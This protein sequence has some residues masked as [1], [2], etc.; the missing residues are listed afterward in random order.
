MKGVAE[1][2]KKG[3]LS[4]L[5]ELHNQFQWKLCALPAVGV[6]WSRND[7]MTHFCTGCV[8]VFEVPEVQVSARC[9]LS[10][11]VGPTLNSDAEESRGSG[12]DQHSFRP[13]SSASGLIVPI[14]FL[15]SLESSS[16]SQRKGELE[17]PSPKAPLSFNSK[18]EWWVKALGSWRLAGRRSLYEDLSV[19]AAALGAKGLMLA[20]V[21]P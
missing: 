11:R 3:G 16:L 15:I 19:T 8:C 7:E 10:A 13:H 9:S 4:N 18:W 12:Q 21:E 1:A 5:R 17:P 2:S 14:S 6:L 20:G